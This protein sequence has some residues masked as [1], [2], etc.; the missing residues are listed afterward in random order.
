MSLGMPFSPFSPE[1]KLDGEAIAVL[2][3]QDEKHDSNT[4]LDALETSVSS[5]LSC[6]PQ[7]C[8]GQQSTIDTYP[9]SV[10][11]LR[12]TAYII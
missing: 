7:K 10:F 12:N 8:S 11:I 5:S 1:S 6:L 3:L 2:H 9:L 4:A